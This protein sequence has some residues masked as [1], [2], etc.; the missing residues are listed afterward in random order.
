[1]DE[2][3]LRSLARA[4]FS[5]AEVNLISEENPRRLLRL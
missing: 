3:P 4:G 1:M 5:A 2:D